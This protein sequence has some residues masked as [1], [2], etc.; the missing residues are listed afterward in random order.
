MLRSRLDGSDSRFR[1]SHGIVLLLGG[2]ALGGCAASNG[3]REAAP[4]VAGAKDDKKQKEAED[5]KRKADVLRAKIEVA[6]LERAALAARQASSLTAARTELELAERE[7]AAFRELDRPTRIGLAELEL[8]ATS[9]RAQEAA[10]ELAQI[11]AMYQEQDLDD[12]TREFVIARGRRHAERTAERIRLEEQRLARLSEHTLRAEE[13]KLVL[14]V[15][16]ARAALADQERMHEVERR[17]KGLELDD[18][19]HELAQVEK[20][21]AAKQP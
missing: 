8:R 16:R 2:L 19:R 1:R 3:A 9:D 15:D 5:D 13:Q 6:E 7:L 12:V 20:K 14:A 10:D 4:A 11:Q 21:L 17:K 18:M